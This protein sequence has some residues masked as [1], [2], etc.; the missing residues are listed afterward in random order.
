MSKDL[1]LFIASFPVS[2]VFRKLREEL[3][4]SQRVMEEQPL[5]IKPYLPHTRGSDHSDGIFVFLT[6][7]ARPPTAN[8]NPLT[9]TWY[10]YP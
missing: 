10:T 4:L 8:L 2:G 6:H 5:G 9:A 3:Q 7:F 1:N